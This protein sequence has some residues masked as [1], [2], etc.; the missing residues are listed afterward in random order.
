MTLQEFTASVEG[1]NPPDGINQVLTAL[2]EDAK[3]HWDTAHSIVQN[4][5]SVEA[6]SVH[7]Y[8][9]REEGDLSNASYWYHRVNKAMPA[10]SLQAEWQALATSLLQSGPSA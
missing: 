3:G 10:I 5:H 2:W 8:L 7:A 1:K 9:H 6:M 4:L